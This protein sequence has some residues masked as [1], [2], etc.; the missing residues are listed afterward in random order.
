MEEKNNLS[1]KNIFFDDFPDQSEEM[2]EVEINSKKILVPIWKK[3]VDFPRYRISYQGEV[4][5]CATKSKKQKLIWKKLSLSIN[6]TG[7]KQTSFFKEKREYKMYVHKLVLEAYVSKRPENL[8]CCH[9]DGNKLNNHVSNLRWDTPKANTHDMYKHNTMLFG[10]KHPRSVL[11]E[12]LVLEIHDLKSKG[13]NSS[14]I[15]LI[16]NIKERTVATVLQGG[17][18]KWLHPNFANKDQD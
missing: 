15:G 16:L 11:T 3:I 8:V 2:V 14:E 6:S 13:A 1:V 12:K 17:N 4:F 18:W 7:Y 10:E 9:N 5:S